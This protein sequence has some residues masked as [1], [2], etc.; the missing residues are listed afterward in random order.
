MRGKRDRKKRYKTF[1]KDRAMVGRTK[2]LR[3]VHEE[4][5]GEIYG[6][7]KGVKE[8]RKTAE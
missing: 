7:N 6:E 4:E 2:R 8:D 5:R 1:D 3:N